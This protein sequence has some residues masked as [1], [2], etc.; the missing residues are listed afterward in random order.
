M[1]R[2]ALE[3]VV[4]GLAS[5]QAAGRAAG[6]NTC[7]ACAE[8][9]G[10]TGAGIMFKVADRHHGSLGS[11][12]DAAAALEELQFTL[13]EG[14]CVDAYEAGRSVSVPDM[15]DAAKHRWPVLIPLLIDAGIRAV[16]AFPLQL[17][18]IRLGALDLHCH[19]PGDLRAE[20]YDDARIV[21]EMVTFALLDLQAAAAT[22]ALAPALE[23][24]ETLRIEVHQAS[25]IVAAQLDV[26][27]GDA[28]VRLRARAYADG[29]PVNDVA[30]DVIARRL[31]IE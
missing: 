5:D 25:G 16:F 22:G 13:G 2:G 3:Q 30:C 7:A 12:D 8:V 11:S 24:A 21:S 29:R 4:A 26:P 31:R 10:T 1:Q 15:D 18:T 20:Q 6:R 14:P 27:V 9:I 23:R 28:L 17:G 19:E